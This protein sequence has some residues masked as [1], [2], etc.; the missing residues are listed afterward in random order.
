MC[1]E[2][3]YLILDFNICLSLGLEDI[4]YLSFT[5]DYSSAFWYGKHSYENSTPSENCHFQNMSDLSVAESFVS[6]RMSDEMIFLPN[7]ILQINIKS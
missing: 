2:R 7:K 6:F 4:S 3:S 1:L 5:L